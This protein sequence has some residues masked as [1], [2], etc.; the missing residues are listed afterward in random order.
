MANEHKHTRSTAPTDRRQE[1]HTPFSINT[2]G[3]SPLAKA[4][5]T[6]SHVAQ[7]TGKA[8]ER[9]A[10]DR[11]Q[12]THTSS[13]ID[14]AGLSPL[15]K[16]ELTASH[17]AQSTGKAVERLATDASI[18]KQSPLTHTTPSPSEQPPLSDTLQSTH[19]TPLERA[20]HTAE[21]VAEST[22]H[23]VRKLTQDFATRSLKETRFPDHIRN[24]DLETSSE[25]SLLTGGGHSTEH[26][27]SPRLDHSSGHTSYHQ[28]LG[29]LTHPDGLSPLEKV[30]H[31]AERV[32]G[33]TGVAV[34]KLSGSLTTTP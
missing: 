5:L 30:T 11:K 10:K 29:D 24:E 23:A 9:L 25:P 13:S 7:S 33:S 4:E 1:T 8:V 19:L 16:A 12:E 22:S 28:S 32:A 3:L 27:I 18:L 34:V 26:H 17:V 14:T 6:A 31:T 2:P 15:A 21:K 20:Q